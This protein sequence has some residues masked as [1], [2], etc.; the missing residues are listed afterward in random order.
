MLL[1]IIK[2]FISGLLLGMANVRIDEQDN[3]KAARKLLA[4][5]K[6]FIIVCADVNETWY[7]L[8]FGKI[9]YF[10]GNT[11]L[12]KTHYDIACKLL[13]KNPKFREWYEFKDTIQ[14]F[15]DIYGY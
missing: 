11:G 8:I 5:A 10:E 15:K 3:P 6:R 13:D 1:K 2:T 4:R 14:K 9:E 7:H 12:A